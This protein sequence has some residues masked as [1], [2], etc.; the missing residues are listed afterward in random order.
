M[1]CSECSEDGGGD[2]GRGCWWEGVSGGEA[3][4]GGGG[5]S[6]GIPNIIVFL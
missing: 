1:G 2:E 6:I 4:V 5:G 3:F